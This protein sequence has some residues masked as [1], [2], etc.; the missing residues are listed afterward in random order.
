MYG[1]QSGILINTAGREIKP[2]TTRQSPQAQQR[3]N[4]TYPKANNKLQVIHD[5]GTVHGVDAKSDANPYEKTRSYS[6][7]ALPCKQV[8]RD[9]RS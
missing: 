6:D 9:V 2:G 8:L 7:T 1:A 4:Q 3:N 5:R